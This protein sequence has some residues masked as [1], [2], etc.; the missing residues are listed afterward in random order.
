MQNDSECNLKDFRIHHSIIQSV[1]CQQGLKLQAC[2]LSL[3]YSYSRPIKLPIPLCTAAIILDNFFINTTTTYIGVV[4]GGGGEPCNGGLQQS[5]AIFKRKWPKLRSITLIM[6]FNIATS[7]AYIINQLDYDFQQ[8]SFL[9]KLTHGIC[10][11][12]GQWAHCLSV[13]KTLHAKVDNI[14]SITS[15]V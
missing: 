5:S 3:I 15:V 10:I 9:Y 8:G 2:S 7:M 4:G 14:T 12:S 11:T 1:I 6:L 13:T